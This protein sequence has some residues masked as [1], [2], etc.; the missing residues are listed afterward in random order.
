MKII[1]SRKG[2]DSA[3]GGCA[4]PIIDDRFLSLPIPSHDT[5][6]FADLSFEGRSYPDLLRTWNKKNPEAKY[7]CN[8]CGVPLEGCHVDPDLE[9]GWFGQIGSAQGYLRNNGV[10]PGDI[11]LFFG[12]FQCADEAAWKRDG[13]LRPEKDAPVIHAIYGWLEVGKVLE[14]PARA[15]E[16]RQLY[17]GHPHA[18]EARLADKSNA[19]YVAEPG[20]FGVFKFDEEL[21]LTLNPGKESKTATW[22]MNRFSYLKVN[23]R[24]NQ[25]NIPGELYY[26][27]IWQELVLDS[28]DAEKRALDLIKKPTR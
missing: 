24:N 5:A 7:F 4:S 18:S 8:S 26:R 19:L 28:G 21:V 12:R 22:D 13:E 20:R 3:N 2:F 17:S 25:S 10:G 14:C 1:L 27:G 15:E 6:R 16:I 11:F 23:G 9:N